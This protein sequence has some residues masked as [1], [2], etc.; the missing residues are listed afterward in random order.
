MRK[1][2]VTFADAALAPVLSVTRPP[3]QAYAE[4]H[5]Y[6]FSDQVFDSK[7]RPQAWAKLVAGHHYLQTYDEMLWIDADVLLCDIEEGVS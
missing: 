5:G 4:K 3:M 7:G 2:I 6:E 1:I